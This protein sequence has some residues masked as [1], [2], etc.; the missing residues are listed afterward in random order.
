M[1]ID[2]SSPRKRGSRSLK[3]SREAGQHRGFVRFAGYLSQLD[4]RLRGND[5]LVNFL[6]LTGFPPDDT[7][8]HS[9]KL[10]NNASKVAG[11]ARE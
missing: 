2:T 4:S 10:A 11:Y 7:T 6:G 3:I 1:P 8:S 5:G 9:T